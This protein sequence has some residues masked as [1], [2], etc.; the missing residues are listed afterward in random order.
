MSCFCAFILNQHTC[1]CGPIFWGTPT[2]GLRPEVVIHSVV[3]SSDLGSM[4]LDTLGEE[5]L[6]GTRI[7]D[8]ARKTIGQPRKR[9]WQTIWCLGKEKQC[10]GN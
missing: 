10:S 7:W 4:F 6:L 1:I 2:A 8:E 9:F 3:V 5:T